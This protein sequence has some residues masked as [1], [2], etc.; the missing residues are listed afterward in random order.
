MSELLGIGIKK[1]DDDG[2]KFYKTVLGQKVLKATGMEHFNGLSKPNKVEA[3]FGTDYNCPE[4]K[5]Y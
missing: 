3:P 1:L 4:A 2:F 5:I